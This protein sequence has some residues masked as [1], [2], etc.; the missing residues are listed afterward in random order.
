M[1]EHPIDLPSLPVEL[2]DMEDQG[3]QWQDMDVAEQFPDADLGN[4]RCVV[5]NVRPIIAK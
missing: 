1:K 3:V 2:D 5:R 4:V